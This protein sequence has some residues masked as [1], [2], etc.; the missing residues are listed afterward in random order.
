MKSTR[1]G[2]RD[3]DIEKDNYERLHCA[4]CGTSLG[5]EDPDDEIY[6]VRRCPDCGVE[7]KELP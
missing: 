4:S 7:F 1:K 6:T 2:L 5:T 3:G